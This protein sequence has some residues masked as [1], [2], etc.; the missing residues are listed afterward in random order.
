LMLPLSTIPLV[1]VLAK[2]AMPVFAVIVPEFTIL[3][4]TLETPNALVVDF[5]NSMPIWPA[6]IEPLLADAAQEG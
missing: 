4:T 1:I 5:P 2:R 3:P 6:L